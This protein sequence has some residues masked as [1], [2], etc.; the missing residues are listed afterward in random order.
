MN[1]ANALP[2][3]IHAAAASTA[4]DRR[5]NSF[6]KPGCADVIT[7]SGLCCCPLRSIAA[8]FFE[9]AVRS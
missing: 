3:E 5:S 6:G 7:S 2:S 1:A 8:L 4:H 9:S